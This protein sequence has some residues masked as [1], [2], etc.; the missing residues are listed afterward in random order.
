MEMMTKYKLIV[1]FGKAGAGKDYL[2][3]R[4]CY[5][6]PEKVNPVV[7]DTTR[8]ARYG[9][10][11]GKDYNFLTEAEFLKKDHIETSFFNSWYYGTPVS[12]LDKNKVNIC[13]LNPDGIRQ[14]YNREDLDIKLFYIS[15]PD[16]TR[17]LRQINREKY[18]NISE[19]C[20]RF[21]ADEEDFKNLY[22][23][24]YRTLRNSIEG[25][26][27]QC[28]PILQETVDQLK[29]DLDRME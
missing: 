29:A 28:T 17:I 22:K 18:P 14:I 12:S 5:L 7:S 11:D 2:L 26:S 24:P 21:L 8:P 3:Q 4:V 10:V 19:I 6:N 1:L 27:E 15:A 16:K 13:V 23:Y 25:I 9:E 20:R